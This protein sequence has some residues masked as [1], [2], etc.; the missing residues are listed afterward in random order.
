MNQPADVNVL[1]GFCAADVAVVHVAAC[2]CYPCFFQGGSSSDG[3]LA[4]VRC[5]AYSK[6]RRKCSIKLSIMRQQNQSARLDFQM[7]NKG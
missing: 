2:H 1:W 7:L 4:S 3:T 5:L 6:I